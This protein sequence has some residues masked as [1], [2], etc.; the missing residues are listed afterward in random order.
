MNYVGTHCLILLC[1][2][3]DESNA[4]QSVSRIKQNNWQRRKL[5]EEIYLHICFRKREVGKSER[6][7][8]AVNIKKH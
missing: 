8:S 7:D 5:L 2:F 4:S 6:E 1:G 3:H